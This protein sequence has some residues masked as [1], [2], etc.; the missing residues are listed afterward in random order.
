MPSGDDLT[1]VL[2]FL[3][4]AF[5]FGLEAMKAET[6]GRRITFM[7]LTIVSVLAALFW[8]KIK[9]IWPPFTETTITVGTNPLA[10]FVVLMF[11]LAVFA[12]HR[13][14][15]RNE[16]VSRPATSSFLPAQQLANAV[17]A[18]GRI[19]VDVGP[20]YLIDLYRGRT[21]IQGDALA[22]AYIGKWMS[23]TAKVSDISD[24]LG[25]VMVIMANDDDDGVIRV[26][27]ARFPAKEKEKI[28]HTARGATIT[29][30]GKICRI[31]SYSVDLENCDVG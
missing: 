22:A 4:L 25:G 29:V 2:F 27:S 20:A 18:L 8:L 16:G 23:I 11:I 13:P 10:W 26:I 31:N 6:S 7:A 17:H 21:S 24:Y 14:K 5:G 30:H 9:T 28:S 3:T 1:I 12:F 15:N 19:Y